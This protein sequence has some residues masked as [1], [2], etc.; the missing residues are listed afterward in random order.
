MLPVTKTPT[1]HKKVKLLIT[2][3]MDEE[4]KVTM[5]NQF[6]ILS[7]N[8]FKK[9]YVNMQKTRNKI[10]ICLS[11]FQHTDLYLKCGPP[12]FFPFSFVVSSSRTHCVDSNISCFCCHVCATMPK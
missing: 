10:K 9:L 3:E 7:N 6:L 4:R 11:R 12:S 1:I 2:S 8:E 5:N